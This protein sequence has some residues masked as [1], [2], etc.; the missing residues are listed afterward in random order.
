MSFR[1]LILIS[2]G[3]LLAPILGAA[4]RGA[5]PTVREIVDR[6]LERSRRI[7]EQGLKLRWTY[8]HRYHKQELDGGEVAK[9]IR[10]VYSVRP[11]DGEPFYELIEHNGRPATAED[12]RREAKLR[13]KFRK[14]FRS[15]QDTAA[16]HSGFEF[17]RELTERF[18]AELVGRRIL[19]GRSMFVLKF[20]PREGKLP[21]NRRMDYA[22][23]KTMGEFWIDA[24][25]YQL[26]RV[27]FHLMEPVKVWAGVLGSIPMLRGTLQLERVDEGLWLPKKMHLKMLGRVLFSSVDQVVDLEWF[28]FKPVDPKRAMMSAP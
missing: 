12:R 5:D 24:E 20:W 19:N 2:A 9:E 13:E 17:D 6:T 4:S 16:G 14:Q 28:D 1:P 21:V 3:A 7:E 18:Q 15:D 22:L 26:A 10:D 25:D 23:N 11:R 8:S 27:D